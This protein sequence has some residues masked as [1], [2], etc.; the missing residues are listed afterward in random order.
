MRLYL[1]VAVIDFV[2]IKL[3]GM[4]KRF[5]HRVAACDKDSMWYNDWGSRHWNGMQ[6]IIPTITTFTSLM[7]ACMIQLTSLME[8]CI[9]LFAPA[10]R[11]STCDSWFCGIRGS[12]YGVPFCVGPFGICV[13]WGVFV[14]FGPFWFHFGR[15]CGTFGDPRRHFGTCGSDFDFDNILAST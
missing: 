10:L 9:S 8:A 3:V 15:A 13:G 6:D 7:F 12:W 5:M 4:Q 11:D 2:V 14:P 1:R